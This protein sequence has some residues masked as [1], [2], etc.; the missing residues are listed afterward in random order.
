M[1]L[2]E[3]F[4]KGFTPREEQKNILA[5]IGEYLDSGYKKIILSAPTG[6]GKSLIA[7]ALAQTLQT[8]F[9]VTNSKHLQ[10]QYVHDVPFLIPVKGKSNYACL[11]T[12]KRQGMEG[13]QAGAIRIGMTCE[14]GECMETVVKDGKKTQ[15]NCMYK[16][17]IK[18]Y[19]AKK[20]TG[21]TCPYYEQKYS[22]LILPHSIWN[23]ASYLQ[24]MRYNQ[25]N[26]G[27]YLN[28]QVVI[29]DEAH[30]LEDQI[31]DFV[32][33][34]LYEGALRECQIKPDE[35]KLDDVGDIVSILDSMCLHYAAELRRMDETGSEHDVE[36]RA[37]LEARYKSAANSKA[38]IEESRGN[39]IVNR[40]ERDDDGNFKRVSVKPVA[41]S[42]YV[43][44]FI[45]SPYQFFMSATISK[46]TFCANI[47]INPEEVAIVDVKRSPF[48]AENRKVEFCNTR[49]LSYKS[50]LEDEIAVIQKIDR[51]MSD[52]ARY[53]GLVLTSSKNRCYQI[54]NN[55]SEEN[56]KRII[57]C[58]SKN[59][60]GKTQ[61]ELLEKH[62]ESKDSVLLSSSLWE[63]VDLKDD[64]SRFQIIAKV[65]YPNSTEN[66]VKKKMKLF[67]FWYRTIAMTKLLQGIGRSVRNSQD[68][69]KTYMLDSNIE[70]ILLHNKQLV[71]K[72]YCD[73][74]NL[75]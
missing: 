10:D 2:L 26:Y 38:D 28:K 35:Y 29:F 18:E 61:D 4:P 12:M 58:H 48:K 19:E 51:I 49:W 73:M 57:I 42:K 14:K 40:P 11:K 9:I 70:H 37:H 45:R 53:K 25:K 13:D 44:S 75:L 64:L 63:G 17:T 69:A 5:E 31:V 16:P 6:I 7:V 59:P 65:P 33:V 52:N 46:K 41:I 39:F 27:H 36:K 20:F 68:W 32:G 15:Q 66:W 50:G 21:I 23:Y 8:S 72:A 62:A 60:G 47:G 54:L 56:S 34:D 67:P 43:E 55:L 24:I 71:P 74:L 3:H 30:K 22:G 1:S